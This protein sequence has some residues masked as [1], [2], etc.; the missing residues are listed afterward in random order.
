MHIHMHT[1]TLVTR[2]GQCPNEILEWGIPTSVHELSV[3]VHC[4]SSCLPTAI[5]T[6]QEQGYPV[7]KTVKTELDVQ[8]STVAHHSP[9]SYWICYISLEQSHT[10]ALYLSIVYS[11]WQHF[12]LSCFPS[13]MLKW[14]EAEL[15]T[16]IVRY[17][18]WPASIIQCSRAPTEKRKR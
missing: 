9:I 4:N 6:L 18:L 8:D 16:C 10:C 5:L 2:A 13:S 17:V 7:T 1:K 14:W 15:E 11:D 12:S 3:C